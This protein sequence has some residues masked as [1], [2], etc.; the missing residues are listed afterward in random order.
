MPRKALFLFLIAGT[1]WG[2]PY[3]F[4]RL[5]VP[6]FSTPSVIFSRVVIGALVLIP[7]AVYRKS[8]MP[9]L[10]AWPWVLAY[11][12]LEMIGPW[13]LITE[14]ERVINSGLAGLL[15][16]TVP[17]F[18]LIIGY[19]YLGDKS[20]A[21]KKTLTG[22]VIGFTG[23]LLLVGIDAFNGSVSLPHVGMV[24]LA[25][26]GYAI[27][28]VIAN[29][30]M[31]NV[32]GVAINGLA[33]AMVAVFYAVPALTA[34]PKELAANP[35]IDAWGSLLGLGVICSALAF[36][37]FFRLTREIDVARASLVT[38]MNMAVAVFLGIILLAEP[39]TAGILIGFPLV[40]VGSILATRK[41]A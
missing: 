19:F 1:A 41:H 37:A 18:G 38:Y 25:A 33:M 5:A 40:V 23:V 3:L 32:S 20:L 24:V 22:L 7:I 12:A 6:Y 28:P 15:V 27:A 21:H 35:P 39:I 9:A 8:L 14:S 34:L 30:K 17:F 4:I 31:P 29:Q 10:K 2:L 36:V 26:L 13:F 16:A 11:A